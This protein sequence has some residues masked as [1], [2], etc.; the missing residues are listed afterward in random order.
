MADW[1]EALDNANWLRLCADNLEAQSKHGTVNVH[2]ETMADRLR[3]AAGELED[4]REE[5]EDHDD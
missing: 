3:E 5:L 2:V 4:L 1:T